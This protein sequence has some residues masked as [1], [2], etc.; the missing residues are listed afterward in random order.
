MGWEVGPGS[1]SKAVLIMNILLKHTGKQYA[2]QWV[3]TLY[4]GTNQ[5]Q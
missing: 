5:Q 1:E 2:T 3:T 4:K